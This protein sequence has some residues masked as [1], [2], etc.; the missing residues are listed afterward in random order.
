MEVCTE[1]RYRVRLYVIFAAMMFMC[2]GGCALKEA[3]NN[4]EPVKIAD[5]SREKT[6]APV[7]ED[8]YQAKD[9]VLGY[10]MP[11]SA[12]I[13][14]VEDRTV[15]VRPGSAIHVRKGMRFSVFREGAP[16]YHP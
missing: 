16:F 5:Q 7:S 14:H 3:A 15:Q 2:A 6:Q 4:S 13:I 9:A 10:F 12:D 1:L 11:V 8:V